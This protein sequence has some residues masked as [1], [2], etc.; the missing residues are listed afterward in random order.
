MQS[1]IR[2]CMRSMIDDACERA[3]CH[4]MLAIKFKIKEP[5]R[6]RTLFTIVHRSRKEGVDE[7]QCIWNVNAVRIGHT[8]AVAVGHI[9]VDR[10]DDIG[11]TQ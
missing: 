10:E 7:L 9:R 8:C 3:I 1:A 6:S 5:C 4:L 2:C 11:V